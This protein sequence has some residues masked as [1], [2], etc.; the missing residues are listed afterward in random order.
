M[1]LEDCEGV[2]GEFNVETLLCFSG[3]LSFPRNSLICG[4][5]RVKEVGCQWWVS[6]GKADLMCNSDNTNSS[7]CR[8]LSFTRYGKYVSHMYSTG[9]NRESGILSFHFPWLVVG[10]THKQ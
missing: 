8:W 5:D 9:S 6:L 2:S 7:I 4:I 10:I 3:I 1:A